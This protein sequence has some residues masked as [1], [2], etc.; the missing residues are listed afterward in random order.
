MSYDVTLHRVIDFGDDEPAEVCV[1]NIGNY[2]SNVTRMWATAIGR[3][4]ADL[5]GCTAGDCIT[6]LRAALI[7]MR[8]RP[9]IY[10]AMN[11]ENGFGDFDGA[12]R[13]LIN[14]HDA[15]CIHPTAT[16]RISR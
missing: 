8:T 2:T 5:D 14:L 11:P 10:E 9:D 1:E 4:L 6:E 7:S 15:C 13:Y 3:P 16:I 12:H